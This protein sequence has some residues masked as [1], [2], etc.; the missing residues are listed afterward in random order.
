MKSLYKQI[1][2]HRENNKKMLAVLLDPD[3]CQGQLMSSTI[4]ALKLSVPDFIFVGGSYV[5]S[6]I[7]SFIELIKEEVQVP[8][9]LFPGNTSQFSPKADALLFLSLISG[10]NPEFLIGQHVT[11]AL[12]IKQSGIEV[13]PA[14]YILID[15]GKVS[16]VEYMSHTRSIPREK[17]EIVLATALAGELSGQ[18]LIYLEAGS[19]ALQPVPKELINYVTSC[20]SIPVIVGGG[21]KNTQNLQDCFDAGANLAVVG[22]AF[23]ENPNL[24]IEFVNFT[25]EYNLKKNLSFI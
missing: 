2:N 14:G 10:R 19:G 23:E 1:L 3:R 18:H 11:S 16:A 5:N 24:I 21:M 9:V 13:I 25:K 8:V 15:G 12:A 20:L 17:K 6:P 22:N 7:D 4:A